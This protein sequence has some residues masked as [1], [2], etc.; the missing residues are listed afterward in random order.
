M[1]VSDYIINFLEKNGVTHIFY[2][3]GGSITHLIDSSINNPNISCI[4]MHHEQGAAFAAEG[5]ARCT[6]KVG[7]AMATSGPGATNLITSIGSCFFDSI[8][9]L[10]ITGQVNTYDYKFD[11][12]IRQSGFQETDIVNIVKPITKGAKLVDKAE[13]ICCDLEWALRLAKSGRPGPV[14]L[15]IPMD[16]QRAEICP[17]L[18][19][20]MEDEEGYTPEISNEI[21]GKILQEL[22]L[23][24]RPVVLIGGGVRSANACDELFKFVEKTNIP[25]VNSLMGLDSFPHTDSAYVGML[26]AYGNR[27]ANLTIANSDFILV[28]GSRLDNR[29]T[30]TRP[31][32]FARSAT[33]VHVDIDEKELNR[34]VRVKYTI[35]ADVKGFLKLVNSLLS[36][37]S[38]KVPEFWLD[39]IKKCRNRFPVYPSASENKNPNK[40]IYN[41]SQKI[42]NNAII[43]VDVGQ[44][45]MWVA[46]SFEVKAKQRML[47]SGGMGAMGFSLP[48]AIGAAFAEPNRQI[49]AIAGDGGIQI[50]IQELQ[51]IVRNKLNIKI[52]VLNNDCLGMVR[53][54]QEIYF[55]NRTEG[56]LQGYD[57]PNFVKLAQAYGIKAIKL[58]KKNNPDEKIKEFLE[59]KNACLLEVML[60]VS[61]VV[62]PKLM[63]NDP[64]EGQI[65]KLSD[66]EFEKMMLIP[67]CSR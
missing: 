58:S 2:L 51:T 55:N 31:L 61:T 62:T 34:S 22:Q 30:G 40:L 42:D 45:Q 41:L 36:T 9:C 39:Y 7:V 16:I 24:Q 11:T 49:I 35:K 8:P 23:A 38:I 59:Y 25:V 53:Q 6:G 54:F 44:H 5:Y 43:S 19:Q 27:C 63:V 37:I 60:P 33:I 46:Q 29:Q 20:V 67:I 17:H 28:L 15:D 50:N 57:C 52:I 12:V 26:G 47:F 4:T 48:A 32:S 14:L 65:P 3:I 10:F 21:M 1:K 18:L 66:E 56:T 13:N 64:I